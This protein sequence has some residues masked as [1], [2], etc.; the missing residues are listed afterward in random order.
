VEIVLYPAIGIWIAQ[1]LV[2]RRQLWTPAHTAIMAF[3]AIL[4]LPT[5]PTGIMP[6]TKIFPGT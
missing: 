6:N 2:T 1:W 4:I 5:C 3:A